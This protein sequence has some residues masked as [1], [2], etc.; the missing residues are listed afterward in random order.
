VK[1]LKLPFNPSVALD[2][3]AIKMWVSYRTKRAGLVRQTFEA[4]QINIHAKNAM[5]KNASKNTLLIIQC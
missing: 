3:S 5:R 4:K 1:P 2:L